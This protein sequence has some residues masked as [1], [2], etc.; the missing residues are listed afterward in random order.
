MEENKKIIEKGNYIIEIKEKD[1]TI[2]K[3]LVANSTI[4]ISKINDAFTIDLQ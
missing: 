2:K 3:I 1:N 4:E